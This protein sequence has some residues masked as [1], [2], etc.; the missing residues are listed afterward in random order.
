MGSKFMKGPLAIA[1]TV[2]VA[3]VTPGSAMATTTEDISGTVYGLVS[4]VPTGS[5]YYDPVSGHYDCIGSS[6]FTGSLT[7]Q[8]V[9]HAQG[10]A[11][12]VTGAEA[13]SEQERCFC[14]TADGHQGELLFAETDTISS[15]GQIV[16]N[17]T[18]IY[19]SGDFAGATGY[20]TMTGNSL[21]NGSAVVSIAG[22]WTHPAYGASNVSS[23]AAR[24]G[25]GR[26]RH[27]HHH[28]R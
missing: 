13:G 1:A 5:D 8:T 23:P 15:T 4:C 7:G 12:L 28:R 9:W 18:I 24:K 11:D 6:T 10:T 2:V 17:G 27:R 16:V 19:G 20:I 21:P 26:H 3:A 14:R 22:R 25:R